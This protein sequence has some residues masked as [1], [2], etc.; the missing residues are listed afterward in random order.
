MGYV[1]AGIIVL[2]LVA[3]FITF[4]VMN[5]M[6]KGSSAARDDGPAGIGPD[7]TPLGDTTEH[8]GQQSERGTTA[9][10]P[11]RNPGEDRGVDPAGQERAQEPGEG[12]ERPGRPEDRQLTDAG[13]DTGTSAP[14]PESERLANRPR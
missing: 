3:G 5:S 12:P 2:L 9:E 8:A 11:E 10:D 14:Q 6:R 7:P 4:L 1:I 13:A